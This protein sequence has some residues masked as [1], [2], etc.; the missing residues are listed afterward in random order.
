MLLMVFGIGGAVYGFIQNAALVVFVNNY[1]LAGSNMILQDAR[2]FTTAI[3][4]LLFLLGMSTA[5][6]GQLML[7]FADVAANTRDSNII[8]RGMRKAMEHGNTVDPAPAVPAPEALPV[9]LP[10]L[11]MPPMEVSQPAQPASELPPAS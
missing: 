7:V 2:F 3:G 5:A 1:W 6:A 4:L 9:V 11:S 8:L 10:P